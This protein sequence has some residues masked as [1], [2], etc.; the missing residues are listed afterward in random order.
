[1]VFSG[2]PKYFSRQYCYC[3]ISMGGR[4]RIKKIN[5]KCH[6]I[7][8]PKAN[9][10]IE[11]MLED[12]CFIRFVKYPR[13]AHCGVKI[14]FH[15]ILH[16]DSRKDLIDQFFSSSLLEAVLRYCNALLHHQDVLFLIL[17]HHVLFLILHHQNVSFLSNV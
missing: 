3:S 7:K 16:G 1:M 9:I 10:A 14:A 4:D 15:C 5:Q 17:H 11:R 6:S 13:Q 8:A 12:C 2:A